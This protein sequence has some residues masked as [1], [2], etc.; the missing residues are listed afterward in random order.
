MTTGS[1]VMHVLHTNEENEVRVC[2]R[3][4]YSGAV[5]SLSIGNTVVTGTVY[6]VTEVASSDPK[7]WTIKVIPKE[8][9]N[10]KPNLPRI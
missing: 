10:F 1:I 4:L 9:P 5:A 7:R 3:A 6:S 2:R 8:A